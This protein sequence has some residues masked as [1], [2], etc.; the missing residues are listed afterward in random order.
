V[1]ILVRRA[2]MP[3]SCHLIGVRHMIPDPVGGAAG[4]PADEPPDTS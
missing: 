3:L 1:T 4:K 2:E